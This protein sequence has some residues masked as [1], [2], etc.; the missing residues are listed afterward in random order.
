MKKIYFLALLMILMQSSAFPQSGW[1]FQTSGT[2]TNLYS[3]YFT[4]SSTGWVVGT[5]GTILKTTNGGDNWFSQSSGTAANLYS[6]HLTSSSTGC[7][8]G[9]SGKILQP[10]NGGDNWASQSRGTNEVMS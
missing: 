6:V 4:S 2:T 5:G 10:T 8:V 9:S 3:V 7:A 1:Q